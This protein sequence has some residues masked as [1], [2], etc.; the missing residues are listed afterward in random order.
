MSNQPGP[1]VSTAVAPTKE[2]PDDVEPY[3]MHVSSRYLD[4]TK[5]KLEL[6]RMPREIRLSSSELGEWAL[7]TPKKVLEPLV[8]FW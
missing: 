3:S 7:G 2:L 8:D 5:K 6:T 4:L 1:G